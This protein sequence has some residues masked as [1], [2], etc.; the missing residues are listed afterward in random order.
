M[1]LLEFGLEARVHSQDMFFDCVLAAEFIGAH[2]THV[3]GAVWGVFAEIED[4]LM[5]Q[6]VPRFS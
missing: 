3:L 2:I 4:H 5:E 1:S 6:W